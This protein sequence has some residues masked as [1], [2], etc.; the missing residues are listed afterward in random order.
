MDHPNGTKYGKRRSGM[1]GLFNSESG[2][3]SPSPASGVVPRKTTVAEGVGEGDIV[4]AMV[5]AIRGTLP[6][7]PGEP[8]GDQK[9]VQRMSRGE[10]VHWGGQEASSGFSPPVPDEQLPTKERLS[11]TSE[12]SLL[13][14]VTVKTYAPAIFNRILA[15]S[16]VDVEEYLSDWCLAAASPSH[17][18]SMGKSA[19]TFVYSHSKKFI[20]KTVR[21]DEFQALTGMIPSYYVHLLNNPNSLI[22][23][24]YGAFVVTK[25]QEKTYFTV[26][27]NILPETVAF[28]VVYDLKGSS[29]KRA[30]GVADKAHSPP[31]LKDNDFTEGNKKLSAHPIDQKMLVNQLVVDISWLES[32]NRMDYS[33]LVGVVS[34]NQDTSPHAVPETV[35]ISTGFSVLRDHSGRS[36]FYVGVIDILTDYTI[37]K[38]V[39]HTLKTKV[40]GADR[41]ELSTVPA[42]AYAT[43]FLSF[44]MRGCFDKRRDSNLSF[45]LDPKQVAASERSTLHRD[46]VIGV[47]D[48]VGRTHNE[49]LTLDILSANV[50]SICVVSEVK[51]PAT[52]S[53]AEGGDVEDSML[54]YTIT[55]GTNMI[56]N[57]AGP[58]S[59]GDALIPS[60]RGDGT[61]IAVPRT[62]TAPR[63][64]VFGVVESVPPSTYTPT[65][66]V[67]KY[68]E[69]RASVG[70][71]FLHDPPIYWQK[72]DL[73]PVAHTV[74]SVQA[75]WID[76]SADE[77]KS[78]TRASI[79][80]PLGISLI[81]TSSSWMSVDWLSGVLMQCG[82]S[83]PIRAVNS[84]VVATMDRALKLRQKKMLAYIE[85][86][87]KAYSGLL[88]T[89][90]LFPSIYE[91]LST[92]GQIHE[93]PLTPKTAKA[94][95]HAELSF[96]GW[97]RGWLAT[98]RPGSSG[99]LRKQSYERAQS[100]YRR[101]LKCHTACLFKPKGLFRR[102]LV[103]LTI[104]E[105]ARA[106]KVSK[107][108][109]NQFIHA[110]LWK[111]VLGI[112]HAPEGES[113][114][115]IKRL[116]ATPKKFILYNNGE[117][118]QE[119]Y[120]L[121]FPEFGHS[122]R[123]L[124]ETA[125]ELD[126]YDLIFQRHL[127]PHRTV[128]D[129]AL[130]ER[131]RLN[132]VNATDQRHLWE[133]ERKLIADLW[134]QYK[135]QWLRS[136]CTL[137]I[138][139]VAVGNGNES[140]EQ[141]SLPDLASLRERVITWLA[142]TKTTGIV[143]EGSSLLVSF[144][145]KDILDN[146]L[147][148]W[149][150]D[151]LNLSLCFTIRRY[152]VVTI[153]RTVASWRD[154]QQRVWET[155]PATGGHSLRPWNKACIPLPERVAEE[156]Q[157]GAKTSAAHRA[158]V[159][160]CFEEHLFPADKG[161]AMETTGGASL[162]ERKLEIFEVRDSG[163]IRLP[164]QVFPVLY[165]TAHAVLGFLEGNSAVPELTW[166]TAKE[167]PLGHIKIEGHGS[168]E[169]YVL[170][171]MGT[172]KCTEE[173]LRRLLLSIDII[174][175][176]RGTTKSVLTISVEGQ[177]MTDGTVYQ[178]DPL[179]VCSSL[180]YLRTE[181]LE[182]LS[183][184]RE[185]LD[186]LRTATQDTVQ[187]C[188]QTDITVVQFDTIDPASPEELP[189]YLHSTEEEELKERERRTDDVPV[190]HRAT[191]SSITPP[192]LLSSSCPASM[193]G[194]I[195]PPPLI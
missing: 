23:R 105:L 144:S 79:L 63:E 126:L 114:E 62:C 154:V 171:S 3:H 52:T 98:I 127:A 40:G 15:W 128:L 111:I 31:I 155:Y 103:F 156:Y 195:K 85:K 137:R 168:L 174:V 149:D 22:N 50:K 145:S 56:V 148:S 58:A 178:N 67:S 181:I 125:K 194:I 170:C 139:A 182:V 100:N 175:R 70:E 26:L 16:G 121:R 39:A 45:F 2:Q 130:F 30:A 82:V 151:E 18:A 14:G 80:N 20:I 140:K 172:V 173:A 122:R 5:H 37:K 60:G 96:G 108:W 41:E 38:Q 10:C 1:W 161:V 28:D 74:E 147:D 104:P 11:F 187:K 25:K 117:S 116:H 91:E 87:T 158:S 166:Q 124:L 55:T 95:S 193:H 93:Q 51:R 167:H 115:P 157:K 84:N 131:K 189:H 118:W 29:F 186:T 134:P 66:R 35:T 190:L 81:K 36:R 191:S 43:R 34:D 107:R 192:R 77:Q 188:L 97:L 162:D 13:G 4:V 132:G 99:A 89:L 49:V 159:L 75:M 57:V 160:Q 141:M 110:E 17:A 112:Y 180:T 44:V 169:D 106:G 143:W 90:P 184:H 59:V 150:K 69:V 176:G 120:G 164:G 33:L 6:L 165:V 135:K 47:G 86:G 119:E 32:H 78:L 68:T 133:M 48:V 88:Q 109:Q 9:V 138:D 73:V 102:I 146:I 179:W 163:N 65:A 185:A 177:A 113:P 12:F 129:F 92:H 123:R 46:D 54:L 61:A 152:A 153:E 183:G 136:W 76:L 24:H 42:D 71:I 64:Y 7:C 27:P 142:S 83:C 53:N 8:G 21:Q 72:L 19:A 94:V 101:N